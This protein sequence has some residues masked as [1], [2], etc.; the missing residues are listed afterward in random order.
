MQVKQKIMRGVI[1]ILCVPSIFIRN[2]TRKEYFRKNVERFI[3]SFSRSKKLVFA[4]FDR[5]LMQIS[6][7]R[8]IT[9]GLSND[10]WIK[11]NE[12]FYKMFL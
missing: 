5:I 10:W 4:E 11:K 8:F 1:D 9:R 2:K 12:F 3:E 6:F 7:Y